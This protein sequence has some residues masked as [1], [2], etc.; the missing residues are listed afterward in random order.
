MKFSSQS[1]KRKNVEGRDHEV[2]LTGCV[3]PR[4]PPRDLRGLRRVV[5]EDPPV[6]E[7]IEERLVGERRATRGEPRD[8][9]LRRRR[10]RTACARRVDERGRLPHEVLVP[11][12][13][14]L[15]HLQAGAVSRV[16]LGAPDD[17][18]DAAEVLGR[19]LE[20]E[21]PEVDERRPEELRVPEVALT[22]PAP[23]GPIVIFRL[24][25]PSVAK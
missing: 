18:H 7:V 20:D 8:L 9:V 14:L 4:V 10:G 12:V 1:A 11:L 13:A 5:V 24:N 19:L 23:S 2:H 17:V 25:L 15:E 16:V 21:L 6:D 3:E 22:A